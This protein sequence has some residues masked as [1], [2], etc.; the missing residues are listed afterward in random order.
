LRPIAVAPAPRDRDAPRAARPVV[1]ERPWSDAIAHNLRSV[2]VGTWTTVLALACLLGFALLPG[3]T[4]LRMVPFVVVWVLAAV[5]TI[6]ILLLPWARMFRS[7]LGQYAMNAWSVMDILMITVAIGFSGGGHS[8]LWVIYILTTLYFAALYPP[9]VQSVLL[10]LTYAS[11]VTVLW[12]TGWHITAAALFLHLSLF[13][14][15]FVLAMFLAIERDHALKGLARQ[16]HH[17]P[18]TGL[19][20]R[21]TFIDGL[22]HALTRVQLDEIVAVLFID[23][24]HFKRIN[25]TFGHH[26]G[27]EVITAVARRIEGALRDHDML[28]RFGGDEFVAMCRVEEHEQVS[29]IAERVLGR[30]D[31]PVSVGNDLVPVTLSVG[32]ATASAS[33]ILRNLDV[34]CEAAADELM[35]NADAAMY[36]AKQL[37]RARAE[38]CFLE[39]TRA[40][41]VA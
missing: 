13:A 18:Q 32:I 27:D 33:F 5:S 19:L 25:D 34:T 36:R 3:H 16:A 39:D 23:I 7:R 41:E 17:D 30:A 14:V 37:G 1:F 9:R 22:E 24:D 8:E 12:I 40:T 35:R 21:Q 2:K 28:A 11:Y 20:R 26:A 38:I 15:E 4:D 6:I 29:E 10:A 31:E